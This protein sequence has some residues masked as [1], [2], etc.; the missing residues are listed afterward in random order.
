MKLDLRSLKRDILWPKFWSMESL[1]RIIGLV[2]IGL[3]VP[4]ASGFNAYYEF[5]GK[6]YLWV[7]VFL[8]FLA[9]V[10]WMMN[11]AG[12]CLIQQAEQTPKSTPR[13]MLRVTLTLVIIS[14]AFAFISYPIFC[15]IFGL[16]YVFQLQL[17]NAIFVVGGVVFV[18]HYYET[19]HL[20][21]RWTEHALRGEKLARANTEAQMQALSHQIDPHF[22]FNSLNALTQLIKDDSERATA[23]VEN[24]SGVYR[25]VLEQGKR[26]LVL[27]EEE[28]AV[29][30]EYLTLLQLRFGQNLQIA[31]TQKLDAN[32]WLIPPVSV[33]TCLENAI[34]HNSITAQAPLTLEILAEGSQ[35]V[36]RNP[37]NL[38]AGVPTSGTGLANLKQRYLLAARVMMDYH[39]T[40]THFVVTLPLLKVYT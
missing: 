31:R 10:C 14:S 7:T 12:L 40:D 28:L 30:E 13:R 24:L 6:Q 2:F 18:G 32:K 23:F 17:Q 19:A 3:A 29:V 8:T 25:Y 35:L 39:K 34:K 37:L 33:L 15:W 11:L 36:I 27:L 4:E 5:S 9:N 38:K 22:L 16:E 20:M 1:M 26:P 21:N